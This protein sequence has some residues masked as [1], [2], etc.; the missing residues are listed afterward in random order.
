MYRHFY[1]C[2]RLY[3]NGRRYV[4]LRIVDPF[5]HAI[6]AGNNQDDPD[7]MGARL[8]SNEEK[9]YFLNR[10]VPLSHYATGT[11]DPKSGHDFKELAPLMQDEL[12]AQGLSKRKYTGEN[13][14]QH[15]Y[16]KCSRHA[17]SRGVISG[18]LVVSAAGASPSTGNPHTTGAI[19]ANHH[20]SA[21]ASLTQAG[22]RTRAASR[23]PP[24]ASHSRPTR[25]SISNIY[26]HAA[27]QTDP[28]TILDAAIATAIVQ[29]IVNPEITTR[30]SPTPDTVSQNS[31]NRKRPYQAYVEDASDKED[32]LPLP[33][34]GGAVRPI[35][36]KSNIKSRNGANSVPR[37]R[38][39]AGNSSAS[40]SSSSY[41]IPE[42]SRPVRR[43]SGQNSNYEF[44]SK[45]PPPAS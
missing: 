41:T 37:S 14:F 35:I 10:I 43:P 30:H 32:V 23:S 44:W 45:Y 25:S 7:N 13:L 9:Q 5:S 1:Q 11:F 39:P 21:S 16:Q 18:G 29:G 24:A 2:H 20:D 6:S 31:A 8:W 40:N 12:D 42:N 26:A 28:V 33:G 4:N 22:F 38:S 17:V 27:T 3:P 19:S 36:P 15:W 34:N